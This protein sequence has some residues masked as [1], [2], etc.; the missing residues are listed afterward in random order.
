MKDFFLK[1]DF[2]IFRVEMEATAK[3]SN[4]PMFKVIPSLIK[5]ND[6]EALCKYSEAELGE[7]PSSQFFIPRHSV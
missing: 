6:L 1:K 4:G 3:T 7:D 2:V 5:P